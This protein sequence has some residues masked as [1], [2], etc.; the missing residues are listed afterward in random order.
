MN[1]R[2]TGQT[3]LLVLG[4]VVLLAGLV[5]VAIGFTQFAG[6]DPMSDDNSPMF[7]FAGGGLAAVVGLGIVAFTR[8]AT[9]RANGGYRIT[10]EEGTAARGGRFCSDCGRPIA[11]TARFC[12]SCG[13]A[14]G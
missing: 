10:I 5:C 1:N 12:D 2:T 11:T 13:A 8:V 3:L 6:T 7:L 4:W 9:M 14:V